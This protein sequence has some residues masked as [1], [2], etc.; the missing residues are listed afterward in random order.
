MTVGLSTLGGLMTDASIAAVP[1]GGLSCVTSDGKINGRGATYQNDAQTTFLQGYRDDFCG[2]TN[3]SPADV[4]GDA[5]GIYNYPAAVSGSGTGSGNGLKA[6]SCRT[7]AW[8]GSDLPYSEAQLGLLNGAPGATGGCGISFTP[9]FQPTPGPWPNANDVQANI[10]SF[11]VA[12]SSVALAVNLP[13]SACGGTAPTGLSFT[14]AQVTAILGGNVANWNDPSLTTNNSSLSGC[15]TPITRVVRF[16]NSGTT[17]IL[18]R[19]LVRIDDSR[20]GATCAPSTTWTSYSASP[21][22]SWPSGSGCSPTTTAGTSGGPALVTTLKSTTGGIG[23]ADL[24]DAV[25][26]GLVLANVRNGVDTGNASP[27]S[28]K[29]ANCDFSVL[30]LPG[31]SNSDA[32]GLNPNDNWGNDNATVNQGSADHINATNLG[33]K[34]PICG[35]TF[36]LVYT[37]LSNGAVANANSRLTADQRRT[38]YSYMTY[39]L[40]S[41]AQ[42]RLSTVNY[43]SLPTPWLGKLRGGFQA[44]Y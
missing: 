41:T 1:T 40:S 39:L 9:P 7:D 6:A 5:M 21:N 15:N 31:F 11:P 38:L 20:S 29:G 19:Y 8:A 2:A 17:S 37:G 4:A 13:A 34:Y 36:D 23:Y 24:A 10:M 25:G 28:G 18:K 30:T 43:A 3:G 16:D 26:Q 12:G 44:A 14:A 42:D 22:T 35:I 33:S 27:A 32:V